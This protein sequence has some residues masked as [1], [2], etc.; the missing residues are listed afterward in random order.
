LVTNSHP[1]AT[2]ETARDLSITKTFSTLRK[3]QGILKFCA[4]NWVQRYTHTHTHTHTHRGEREANNI[5]CLVQYL[6]SGKSS[7]NSK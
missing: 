3:F 1:G 5:K 7:I 6:T 4:R 2:K